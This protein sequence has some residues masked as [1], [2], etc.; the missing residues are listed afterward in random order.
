M[1][2]DNFARF[3]AAAGL[4]VISTA[5]GY[6]YSASPLIYNSLPPTL[7]RDPSAAE[8]GSLFRE[9]RLAGVQYPTLRPSGMPCAN[10][11]VRDKAYGLGSLQRQFRQ[12]VQKGMA[13]CEIRE[14][15][16]EM[17]YESGFPINRAA[18]ARRGFRIPYL[19]EPARWLKFC[20]AGQTTPGAGALASFV[21]ENLAAYLIYFIADGTCYGLHMLSHP[22]MWAHQPNHVLYYAFTKE[23]IAR[24]DIQAVSIGLQS[25]PAPK[26]IDQF[27][28]HAGYVPEPCY[29]SIA[30]RPAARLLLQ[31]RAT[32]RL[33]ASAAPLMERNP[34]LKRMRLVVTAAK[35]TTPR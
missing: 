25:L 35:Q 13:E 21:G 10:F 7:A 11:V 32:A 31:N 23:L 2:A 30:L 3:Y 12:H 34:Q 19:V 15:P 4:K 29:V 24:P 27:K 20:E 22:E 8:L 18:M 14:I 1:N 28:R 17:L 6:W 16:F 9:H 33:L 26:T 5:S